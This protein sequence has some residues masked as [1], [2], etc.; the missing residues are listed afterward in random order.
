MWWIV[1]GRDIEWDLHSGQ[2]GTIM[3]KLFEIW[4]KC[5][6]NEWLGLQLKLMPQFRTEALEPYPHSNGRQQLGVLEAC[7][8]IPLH[9]LG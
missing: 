4:S 2:M 3:L 6:H 7:P 1:N 9:V 5:L 8:F